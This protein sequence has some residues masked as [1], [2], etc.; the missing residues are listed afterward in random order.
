[1][2]DEHTQIYAYIDQQ[3][4]SPTSISQLKKGQGDTSVSVSCLPMYHL[5][6]YKT[7]RN[8]YV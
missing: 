4:G 7:G 1:M 6:A 2:Y 3:A 5:V 8:V